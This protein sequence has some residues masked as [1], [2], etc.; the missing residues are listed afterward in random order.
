PAKVD[1][2]FLYHWLDYFFWQPSCFFTRKAWESCG[3]LDEKVHYAMD[4]DLWLKISKRS[5]FL[6]TNSDLSCSLKHPDAKTTADV[7]N[8][9]V[10]ALVVVIRHGGEDAAKKVMKKEL[11]EKDRQLHQLV[12][13]LEEGVGQL[14]TSNTQI[15]DL[16][17]KL[18][19]ANDRIAGLEEQLRAV[20]ASLSWRSTRIVRWVGDRIASFR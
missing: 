7:V 10:E 16:N 19:T 8:T 3:P 17:N 11:T 6:V 15:I 18:C 4:L 5:S 9:L 20:Y 13:E 1:L 2:D 12:H 14:Y